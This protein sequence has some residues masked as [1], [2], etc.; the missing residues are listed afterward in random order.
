MLKEPIKIGRQIVQK[1]FHAGKSGLTRNELATELGL[2]VQQIS[3]AVRQLVMADLVIELETM[4][5]N[6]RGCKVVVL[7]LAVFFLP[8]PWIS[9]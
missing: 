8:N 1:L 5:M 2:L 6:Q 3:L 7:A 4:R 9:L